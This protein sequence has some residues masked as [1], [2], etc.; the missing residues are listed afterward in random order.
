[1]K[2]DTTKTGRFFKMLYRL[3]TRQILRPIFFIFYYFFKSIYMV[4]KGWWCSFWLQ[5]VTIL[6]LIANGLWW[7]FFLPVD[8]FMRVPLIV[9]LMVALTCGCL[10]RL[11][12]GIGDCMDCFPDWEGTADVFEF[13]KDRTEDF[14]E[15]VMRE[16]TDAEKEVIANRRNRRKVFISKNINK[17]K[18]RKEKRFKKKNSYSR[19]DIMDLED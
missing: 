8:A 14:V 12:F 15:D 16:R 13:V 10:A 3:L 1:M 2:T 18:K 7:R 4:F 19:A 5:V 6:L 9:L 11:I 17:I